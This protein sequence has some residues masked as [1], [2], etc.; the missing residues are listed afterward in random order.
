MARNSIGF[1]AGEMKI[2][3]LTSSWENSEF[4]LLRE[5]RYYIGVM[6]NRSNFDSETSC[7]P[8]CHLFC[9]TSSFAS[10]IFLV[11]LLFFPLSSF[12]L[13]FLSDWT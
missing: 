13:L 3:M 1:A 4:R 2:L 11:V 10:F 5:L 9:G 8:D 12:I 7:S 6:L